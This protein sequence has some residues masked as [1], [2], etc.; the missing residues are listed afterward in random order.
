M[1]ENIDLIA[2]DVKTNTVKLIT[3]ADLASRWC[4]CENTLKCW[5]RL[6]KGPRFIKM[7]YAVRY[8]LDDVA[9]FEAESLRKS[10]NKVPA[11]G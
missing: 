3:T 10:V 8:S 6:G 4:L 1:I 7:N 11:N 9:Q 5:R 2:R